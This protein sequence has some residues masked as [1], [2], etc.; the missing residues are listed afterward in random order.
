MT[1]AL[2]LCLAVPPLS[3]V[4]HAALAARADGAGV[5]TLAVGEAR[6]DSLAAAAVVAT[7][8]QR[9]GV[10]TAVTTWTRTPATAAAGAL[11]L[12]E[13]SGGRFTLGLGTMPPAWNR[14]F[15]G[16]DPSRPLARIGEYVVALRAALAA[17]AGAP[18]HVDGEFFRLRGYGADRPHPPAHHVP[19]HLAATRP[20]MARLAAE[21]GDGVVVNVVHTE[22][23][24]R[25]V[26]LPAVEEGERSAGRRA[27]RSVML[28]V[29]LHDG[30]EVG[31]WRV[32]AQSLRR[33]R[34]VPYFRQVAERE[35]LDPDTDDPDLVGRFVAA[36]T[37]EDLRRR[38]A[39]YD[40]WADV[41]LLTPASGLDARQELATYE[42][43]LTLAERV[44]APR[45]DGRPANPADPAA[46]RR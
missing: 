22:Q 26:L 10:M 37:L 1:A 36:G 39:T 17:W 12:A 3:L 32:A 14:D 9:A 19:V 2:G 31:A 13:L 42:Q 20:A 44:P 18:A 38:L 7:A 8:T 4:E 21:I 27:V 24:V 43:L 25:G 30:D 33:Y 5:H 16:I 34:A 45:G 23:W 11:T 46:A 15:H 41:V 6:Y 29:V 28:R 40:D 35:G